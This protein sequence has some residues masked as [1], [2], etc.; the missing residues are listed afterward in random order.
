MHQQ[1]VLELMLAMHKHLPVDGHGCKLFF[2][3][4]MWLSPVAT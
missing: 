2:S 4:E 1:G 3:R